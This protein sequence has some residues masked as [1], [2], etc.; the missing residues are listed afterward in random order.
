M[1][2]AMKQ[3]D[4]VVDV[5]TGGMLYSNEQTAILAAGTRILR[6]R[7]PDDCLLRLLPSEDVQ[8]P[9]PSAAASAARRRA[10]IRVTSDDGTDLTMEQ[11]RAARCRSS[12]A[13]P[14]SRAAGT[15]GRPG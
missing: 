5:T 3:A 10:R 13:W 7:E 8:G 9:Q 11:G 1:I 4:F 12:T 2:E 6:V 14:T 15:I